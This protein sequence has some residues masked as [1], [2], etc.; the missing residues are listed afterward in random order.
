[1]NTK[2]LVPLKVSGCDKGMRVVLINKGYQPRKNNPV[3]N[4]PYQ[5]LGTIIIVFKDFVR[6]LWDNESTNS[7][8]DNDLALVENDKQYLDI[9]NSI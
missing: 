8:K 4:T 5:C 3:I 7:Y 6:V 2:N 9:W 1:M